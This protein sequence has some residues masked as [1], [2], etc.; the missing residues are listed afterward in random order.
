MSVI[1]CIEDVEGVGTLMVRG[2]PYDFE[3]LEVTPESGHSLSSIKKEGNGESWWGM[4]LNSW[5]DVERVRAEGWHDGMKEARVA[6]AKIKELPKLREFKRRRRFKEFGD[7]IL[8]DRVYSGQL[9]RAWET[10]IREVRAGFD[11]GAI[12]ILVSVCASCGVDARKMFWRGAAAAVLCEQLEISGKPVEIVAYCHEGNE[13]P[14]HRKCKNRCDIVMVKAAGDPLD[15]DSL[16]SV[17]CMPGWFRYYLFKAFC[18]EKMRAASGLGYPIHTPP[19][20]IVS[21]GDLIIH[22]V[23]SKEQAQDYV[24]EAISQYNKGERMIHAGELGEL[25]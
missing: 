22:N 14:D 24:A 8:M 5:K 21:E 10:R 7:N 20:Q 16:A 13:Y 4:G 1:K 12:R 3:E 18:S 19:P 9:D 2:R 15:L 17:I 6:A 11:T 23:W 25:G